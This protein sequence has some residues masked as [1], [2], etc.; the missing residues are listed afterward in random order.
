MKL[1]IIHL[2]GFPAVA[3]A[4]ACGA[5]LGI[6]DGERL[7]ETRDGGVEGT[8][9]DRSVTEEWDDAGLVIPAIPDAHCSEASCASI[10]GSCVGGA[11]VIDCKK[12]GCST[13]REIRCPPDTDCQV[14]C[15]AD[16]C[17]AITCSGGRSCG[18]YCGTDGC[19][20]ASCTSDR[21]SFDCGG[22]DHACK[23]VSCTSKEACAM[24][25]FAKNACENSTCDAGVCTFEC[26]GKDSCPGLLRAEARTACAIH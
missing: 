2:A 13:D 9:G 1:R 11:C 14:D 20:E 17:E 5:I 6:D 15:R 4:T 22:S 19:N 12:K 8:T 25:C 3:A 21:C 23:D 7:Q 18:L 16:K 24:H 10:K 26:S